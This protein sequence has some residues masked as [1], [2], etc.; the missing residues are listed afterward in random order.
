MN[1]LDLSDNKNRI[2]PKL[3]TLQAQQAGDTEFLLTDDQRL[4]FAETEDLANRLA[5]G[6]SELGVKQGDRVC[7]YL[8]SGI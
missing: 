7:F 4:S 3:L 1:K 5:A 2:L 8:E 6:M